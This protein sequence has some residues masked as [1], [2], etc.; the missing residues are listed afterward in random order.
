MVVTGTGVGPIS[1]H[2]FGVTFITYSLLY[3]FSSDTL[4]GQY[5]VSIEPIF[6]Q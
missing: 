3:F 1:G 6:R 2:M 4:L 5:L